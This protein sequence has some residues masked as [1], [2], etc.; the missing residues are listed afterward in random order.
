MNNLNKTI[1]IDRDGTIIIEPANKQIDSLQKLEF[2]PY[3]ISS[4][5]S[6]K[7]K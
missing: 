4:L 2:L 7:D 5:K 3:A 6:L 1:F